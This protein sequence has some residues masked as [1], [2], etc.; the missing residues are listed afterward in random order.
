[1]PALNQLAGP[2][3]LS[4][5]MPMIKLSVQFGK[6]K[7]SLSVPSATILMLLVILL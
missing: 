7:M 2:L 1:M 4:K 3:T 6:L 5:A